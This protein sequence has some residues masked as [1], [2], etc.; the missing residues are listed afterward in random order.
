MGASKGKVS[1]V[2]TGLKLK[3]QKNT[4]SGMRSSAQKSGGPDLIDSY[5]YS[6]SFEN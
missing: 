5:V 2:Q 4:H 3:R 6:K 1:A